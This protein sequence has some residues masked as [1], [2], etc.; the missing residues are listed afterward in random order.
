ME[1]KRQYVELCGYGTRN[2]MYHW[3]FKVMTWGNPPKMQPTT[4]KQGKLITPEQLAASG[5]EDGHQMA[6]F[7][8]AALNVAKYPALKWLHSIPN[9]GQRHIAEATKMVAAGLRGG[10]LDTFLPVWKI[11]DRRVYHGCYIEMKR[12]KHRNHKNGGCSEDQIEFML[13]CGAAGYYCKVCYNWMEAR[14]TLIAYLEG[15]L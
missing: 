5:S 9:G 6:L 8:W 13:Y 11:G 15:K 14:D 2:R 3:N 4:P 12:E 7:C 10:V 1:R